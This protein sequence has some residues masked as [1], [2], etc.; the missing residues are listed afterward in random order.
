MNSWKFV[1]IPA[2]QLNFP[3][4]LTIFF[5]RKN[6]KQKKFKITKHEKN[7]ESLFTF[8]RNGDFPSI[9]NDFFYKKF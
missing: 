1:Y 5:M 8:Q 4:N 9:L 7:R 2:M 6:K 3:F